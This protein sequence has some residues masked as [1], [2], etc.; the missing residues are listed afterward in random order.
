M[1]SAIFSN[2]SNSIND[3]NNNN[4]PPL[5]SS[6]ESILIELQPV[7]DRLHAAVIEGMA[8]HRVNLNAVFWR[9]LLLTAGIVLLCWSHLPF[10]SEDSSQYY[11]MAVGQNWDVIKPFSSRYFQPL[12][13]RSLSGLLHVSIHQAFLVLGVLSLG[14]L[15]FSLNWL[16]E[17][18]CL[19]GRGWKA[20]LLV[21]TP[22]LFQTFLD[23]YLP[24]L[25]HA[26]LLG[27]FFAL[28][29]QDES[30]RFCRIGWVLVLIALF[31]TKESTILLSGCMVLLFLGRRQYRHV[32]VVFIVTLFAVYLNALAGKLGRPNIHSMND[33]LYMGLKVPFNLIKNFTGLQIWADTFALHNKAFS[34]VF[35]KWPLPPWLHL[36]SIHAIGLCRPNWSFPLNTFIALASDFGA[37]P[38]MLLF[39]LRRNLR[40]IMSS[41]KP[42]LLVALCYGSLACIM[43]TCIGASGFR[44]I[45]YGW[46]CFWL[47]TLIWMGRY[48][49]LTGPNAISFLSL[50]MVI[51]W[52]PAILELSPLTGLDYCIVTTLLLLGLQIWVYRFLRKLPVPS[53]IL[54]E[55][56]A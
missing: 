31:A 33:L 43:G 4:S 14:L 47:A 18:S 52:I 42:W 22:L 24:D 28:L 23:Y 27:L 5:P 20:I 17:K 10:L 9:P 51:A 19:P 3:A 39:C 45:G 48:L 34:E 44:L 53:A 41:E 25:L 13:V 16:L 15:V 56:Y 12:L 2:L 26:A 32:F 1:I 8:N 50:H 11:Q 54:P 30:C 46:P 6:P 37:L 29:R 55:I 21:L 35:V 40:K 49:P 38:L 36:G 7:S